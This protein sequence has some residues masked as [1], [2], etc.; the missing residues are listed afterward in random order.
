LESKSRTAGRNI[1]HVQS[2]IHFTRKSRVNKNRPNDE[3]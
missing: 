1:R 2:A 3:G